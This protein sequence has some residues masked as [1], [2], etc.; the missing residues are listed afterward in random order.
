M[1]NTVR[2]TSKRKL[3]KELSVLEQYR[4]LNTWLKERWA[5]YLAVER[6]DLIESNIFDFTAEST[7]W[8]EK[9][10]QAKSTTAI[11]EFCH[12]L[13]LIYILRQERLSI[14]SQI[15]GDLEI[16]KKFQKECEKLIITDF[17][18]TK[19]F[20]A[21]TYHFHDLGIAHAKRGGNTSAAKYLKKALSRFLSDN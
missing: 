12:Q 1:P 11:V 19:F 21:L 16:A 5:A 7:E 3:N 18:S 2:L 17:P 15:R 4:K 9:A 6:I 20:A 14:S 10:R 13:C 8:L